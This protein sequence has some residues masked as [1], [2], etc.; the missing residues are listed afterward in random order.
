MPA[1]RPRLTNLPPKLLPSGFANAS[2]TIRDMPFRLT[3]LQC[4]RTSTLRPAETFSPFRLPISIGLAHLTETNFRFV[5]PTPPQCPSGQP[6]ARD[7][8]F[9]THQLAFIPPAKAAELEKWAPLATARTP[10]NHQD[11]TGAPSSD[12]AHQRTSLLAVRS[13]SASVM[14]CR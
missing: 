14:A 4:Q 9:H 11:Q 13:H 2:S 3:S 6:I 8:D 1:R 12:L 10:A 7:R 5:P